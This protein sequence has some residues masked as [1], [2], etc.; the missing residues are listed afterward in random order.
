MS[1]IDLT[2]KIWP[3]LKLSSPFWIASAHYSENIYI[4]RKWREYAPAAITLKTCTK[5]D[6]AEPEL[7]PLLRERIQ[8]PLPRYGRGYYSDGPKVRELKSYDEIEE[9]LNEARPLLERTK[10]GVSVLATEHEDFDDL[11]KRC[12]HADFFELNLKYSMRSKEV[13]ESFFSV[14]TRKWTEMIATV[15]LF[16]K[17]FAG[18]PVLAII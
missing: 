5:M 12:E 15:E 11:R 3:S 14:R 13:G 18:V 6:R 2:T 10:L 8:A 9:L 4:L 17:S 16:L 1:D 7:K